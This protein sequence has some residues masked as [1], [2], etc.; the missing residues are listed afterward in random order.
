[1]RDPP[2]YAVRAPAID[3]WHTKLEELR[4]HK[5]TTLLVGTALLVGCAQEKPKATRGTGDI[6]VNV[7]GVNITVGPDGAEVQA[8]GV[9]VKTDSEGA[10]VSAPGVEVKARA[11]Q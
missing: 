11:E 4:M 5:W 8:P 10:E 6:N 3:G 9:S 1:L 7:P 2:E